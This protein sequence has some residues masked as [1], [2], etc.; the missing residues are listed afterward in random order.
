MTP[1][2]PQ[3]HDLELLAR[4]VLVRRWLRSD[5]SLRPDAFIPY[6]WPDLS[7]TRHI[8]LVEDELWQLGQQVAEASRRPLLGRADLETERVR[9]LELEVQAAPVE[10]NANHANI[11]G[12]PVDKAHQKIKALELAADAQFKAVPGS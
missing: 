10:G 7:V 2:P 6:P 8:G 3:V 1:P 9:H 5:E 12:W 11:T 4:F